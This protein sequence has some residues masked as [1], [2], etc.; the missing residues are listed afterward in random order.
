LSVARPSL[1]GRA[2]IQAAG[3]KFELREELLRLPTS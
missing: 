1:R 3:L 2:R